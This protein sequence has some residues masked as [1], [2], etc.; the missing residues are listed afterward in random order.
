[1]AKAPP[2]GTHLYLYYQVRFS[3][4]DPI[5]DPPS[6][7][8]KQ[9]NS[10]CFAN[11]PCSSLQTNLRHDLPKTLLNSH[12]LDDNDDQ[13]TEAAFTTPPSSYPDTR[14]FSRA[15]FKQVHTGD[16]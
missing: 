5:M 4:R 6:A 8:F 14:G 9:G 10:G 7:F 12:I 3:T 1:V 15:Y 11:G 13:D 16:V 2:S